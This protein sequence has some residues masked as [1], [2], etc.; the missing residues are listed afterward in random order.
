M[1]S[2]AQQEVRLIHQL[3][4]LKQSRHEDN[5]K[6]EN[7]QGNIWSPRQGRLPTPFSDA[8]SPGLVPPGHTL[9]VTSVLTE[10]T[11]QCSFSVHHMVW[12]LPCLQSSLGGRRVP[13]SAAGY[14]PL[15]GRMSGL[16]EC[17]FILQSPW[18]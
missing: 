1:S 6:S 12:K 17:H 8:A 2:A 3:K 15:E 5:W 13:G 14:F 16:K 7:T 10:P 18:L 4:D 9:L 11:T